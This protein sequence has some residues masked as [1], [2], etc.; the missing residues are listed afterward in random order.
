M[1]SKFGLDT[2]KI[3][4]KAPL[5]TSGTLDSFSMVDL[6]MHLEQEGGFRMSPGEVNLDNLDS[7]SRILEFVQSKLA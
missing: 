2:E 1:R 5:F 6:V 3:D 7:I 4:D